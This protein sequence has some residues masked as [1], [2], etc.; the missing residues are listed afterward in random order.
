MS[1]DG[2]FLAR[3]P[4]A[5]DHAFA[6]LQAVADAGPGVTARELQQ[7]LPFSRASLY[8]I[9]RHLV[10]QEYL[11][12]TPDLR[13]FLLGRRV[14]DLARGVAAHLPAPVAAERS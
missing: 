2:L 6:V 14:H 1:D 3:Q 11:V 12:R 7:V 10:G 9:L 5:V 8:R 4:S 13:G